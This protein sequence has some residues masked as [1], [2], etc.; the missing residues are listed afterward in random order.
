MRK[1]NHKKKGKASDYDKTIGRR[2]RLLRLERG[3]TQEQLAERLN[4]T[5]QQI[6]KYEKGTNR[7]AAGRLQALAKI[8]KVPP[9]YFFEEP[10]KE[11]EQIAFDREAMTTAKVLHAIPHQPTKT[12]LCSLVKSL[13]KW[14][15][16]DAKSA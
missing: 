9:A 7:V 11:V 12:H 13:D 16:E 8:L 6:Q 10:D 1:D 2:L 14:M 15:R 4:I 5:F 3:L